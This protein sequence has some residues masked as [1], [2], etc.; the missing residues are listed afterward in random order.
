ML[1]DEKRIPALVESLVRAS[2][3]STPTSTFFHT[4][5]G[6]GW[7]DADVDASPDARFVSPELRAELLRGRD[8]FATRVNPPSEH[9]ER[10][11]HLRNEIV[12]QLFQEGGK[13]M[14]GSDC[15][16]GMLLYGFTLHREL[17]HLVEAGLPPYAAL[18]AATKNPAEWLGVLP[19]TGTIAV[20]KR[21]DLV[22]LGANPLED[23]RNTNRIEGV[24]V[25][26]R[27]LPRSELDALLDRSA[28]VLSK[29]PLRPEYRQ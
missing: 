8:H 16:D 22:L 24:V 10:Y 26:G 25:R 1:L 15:P 29:A 3:W 23:I 17:E 7:S 6:R 2:V 4:I 9:R 19:E 28:E 20:G 18:E 11:V 5:F 14:A 12:R 27:W 13:I 21:A